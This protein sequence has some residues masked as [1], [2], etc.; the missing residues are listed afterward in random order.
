[1]KFSQSDKFNLYE[2]TLMYVYVLTALE[3]P[4]MLAKKKKPFLPKL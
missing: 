3:F 1:M 4:A 2:R